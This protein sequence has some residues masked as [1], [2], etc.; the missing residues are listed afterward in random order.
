[1]STVLDRLIALLVPPACLACRGPLA[2]AGDP[3]CAACRAALPWLGARVCRRSALPLPCPPCPA[4]Q[5]AFTRAWAPFAHDGPARGLVGAL[6]FR[7][8]TAV[9]D[10]MGA[11]VA[12][13]APPRLLRG[14]TLVP[15]PPP[16]ARRRARGFDQAA[17]LADAVARRTGRPLDACLA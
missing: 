16:P 10:V 9:A 14:A 13:N 15:V 3:L 4:R 17:L 8:H 12:A 5:A 7:G 11:H 6:K 1:M 2:R